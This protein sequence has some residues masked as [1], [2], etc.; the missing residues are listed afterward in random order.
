MD[1]AHYRL[2]G[3]LGRGGMGVV[4]RAVDTRLGRPVALKLLPPDATGDPDRQRRFI[5]EARAASA[6]NHPHIVTIYEVG[7][8]EGTT[9]I[10][11]ELVE[12]IP[13]DRLL[14][15][16]PLAV[17]TAL[18]YAVQMA[19]ALDAAHAAGIVRCDIKLGNVVVA[20]GVRCL[21]LVVAPHRPG[22]DTPATGRAKVLDF[23]LA[24]LLERSPT[25]A[26]L[27]AYG[28]T[29]GTIL[30]TAA[31][32]S[33]EQA[34]GQPVDARS[35]IFSFG[36]VLY[37]MFSGRRPF[38]GSS[39]VGL[40]TSILRDQ[41]PSIRSL[42]PEMPAEIEAIVTRAL[43]KN[44]DERY[45]GAA[46]ML[47]DLAEAQERLT[48]A[49]TP[50][51]RR[52]AVLVPVAIVLLAAGGL[53]IWQTVQIRRAR[54][55]QTE[56]VAE[57]ERLYLSGRTMH[58]VRL[59][60]ELEPLAPQEVA[61]LRNGWL[62]FNLI[63]D[64]PGA[65][66]E[67]KNYHDPEGP[68]EPFGESPL[69]THLPFGYYRARISKPGF[70]TVEVS[71]GIGRD[72][73]KLTNDASATPGMVFVPGG[74]I[75]VGI[76]PPAKIPDYWIDRYESTNAEFKRFVDAG[77]YRDAKYWNHPFRDGGRELT[78]DEAMQRFRDSTNR[79]GPATWE[80]GSYPD[81]AGE[82]PVGGISW[83]EAAAYAEFTG[84]SLPTL[85]HWFHAAGTDEIHSD[86]LQLSNFDGKGPSK[87]GERAGLGPWGTYDMAGNVKEWAVNPVAQSTRYYILGGG[88]NEPSYRFP[89]ADGQDPWDRQPTFGVRLVRS[90]G[91]S[92]EAS[93][94]VGRVNPD[95]ST[96]IPEPAD[97]VAL[98][99][100]FYE[101]DRTPLS[102]KIE[103]VDDSSPYWRKEKVVYAAAY[104]NDEIPAFVFLPKNAT[105]PYQTV[106]FFPS[107]YARQVPSSDSLD[108]GTF[109]FLMRSGR[110]VIYPVYQGTF[111]RRRNVQAGPSGR[112]DMMVQ[113]AKDFFRTID[114]LETR[115]D[116]DM[117]RLAYYSL[118]MG[119]YFGPIPV[120]LEPRITVAVFAAGGLRYGY[121]PEIQPANFAPH[122][123]VPVLTV[124]GADDFGVPKAEQLRF[125]ELL[126]TPAEHKKHVILPGGHVP[127]DIRGLFREVLDWL[128]K[129]LGPV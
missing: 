87:A 112:R 109:E 115:P 100:R 108:L 116:I 96:V 94:A 7:E 64:P 41:P 122:V 89:E 27:S 45:P 62:G 125:V 128:D 12:G 58:A 84:K 50:A 78:F 85:Y 21:D 70:T 101:Y 30:G 38:A 55:A 35:D 106:V 80:L 59:A 74:V 40:L 95:P 126:G 86:I 88:W 63:T 43:A 37:E 2:E 36:A 22:L 92:P 26:T 66:V 54:W 42:R 114:Y 121:P 4:Y 13:L 110:A 31:Y 98:Y 17:G 53:G 51:W 72:P 34:Q 119:A 57:I 25:D 52:P 29:P 3:E 77:G 33:P 113:W 20:S 15:S 11:M 67:V 99:K 93:V 82:Y 81:G 104:G 48:R 39:D 105:P 83:F 16:G 107:A 61:R 69:R 65:L 49:P 102:V 76:A 9:F 75:A 23:G 127:Q 117:Q 91:P 56:G 123:K 18:T 60:R 79:P 24:K 46:A 103:S 5:Q 111:E 129:Y 71:A 120:S 10:A 8:H 19:G 97:R 32:M 73:V 124:H 44:P 6:L 118:S 28:T 1:I 14:A 47:D 68:W 90:L